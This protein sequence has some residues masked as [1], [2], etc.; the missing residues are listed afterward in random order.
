MRK[1]FALALPK[2]PHAYVTHA[3]RLLR[4]PFCFVH[5]SFFFIFIPTCL[6]SVRSRAQESFM[7]S[8]LVRSLFLPYT[9]MC[10]VLDSH[11][12]ARTELLFLHL[13]DWCVRCLYTVL[14]V[15]NDFFYVFWSMPCSR[16]SLLCVCVCGRPNS[17][18]FSHSP[19]SL[20]TLK[21]QFGPN[22]LASP[23]PKATMSEPF[24]CR[25]RLTAL[26]RSMHHERRVQYL[27][28]DHIQWPPR[29]KLKGNGNSTSDTATHL[30]CTGRSGRGKSQHRTQTLRASTNKSKAIGKKSGYRN[31]N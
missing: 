29:N 25:Q 15:F 11:F 13:F 10:G 30:R 31:H 5:S 6:S 21:I 18:S 14:Y 3:K 9:R 8:A 20:C 4:I 23:I 28:A 22:E 27:F 1:L 16:E 19:I 2:L 26:P 17:V 12:S 7:L 24:L